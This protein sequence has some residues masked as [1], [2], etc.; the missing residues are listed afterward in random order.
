MSDFEELTRR[1]REGKTLSQD[2]IAE[3]VELLASPKD[4]PETKAEFLAA[5]TAKGETTREI[6][7]F[8]V[9]LR[10]R[11]TPVPV[12]ET[13]RAG[14]MI[15]VCGTGGD[16]LNTFNISSAAAIIVAANNAVREGVESRGWPNRCRW[17]DRRRPS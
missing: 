1:L 8:A 15:D 4:F 6:G 14:T 11:A 9:E 16:K 13:T 7:G 3:A 5:L 2:E 10:A 12:D 17:T